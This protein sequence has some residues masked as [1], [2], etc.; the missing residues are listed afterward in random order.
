MPIETEISVAPQAFGAAVAWAAKWV[1]AKPNVPVQGGLMLRVVENRLTVSA[2]SERASVRATVECAPYSDEPGGAIVSGRLLAALC[3]TLTSRT[4]VTLVSIDDGSAVR[5]TQG[6]WVVTLPAMAEGDY[7]SVLGEM[8]EIGTVAGAELARAVE[9]I[10]M[11][12]PDEGAKVEALFHSM[13]VDLGSH[14]TIEVVSTDRYRVGRVVFPWTPAAGHPSTVITPLG[15]MMVDAAAAFDGPD[16]VRIGTDGNALSLSSPTRSLT[17]TTI[18]TEGKWPVTFLRSAG[19]EERPCVAVIE[20]AELIRPLKRASIMRGKDG[21][22]AV[23]F[24][25]GALALVASAETEGLN[26]RSDDEMAV[27]YTGPEMIVGFNPDYFADALASAPGAKVKLHF[28][29]D[30]KHVILTSDDDPDWRH[31]L[32]PVVLPR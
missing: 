10:A 20:P 27:D 2:Y 16:D 7:P 13:H 23:R 29:I 1:A 30:R 12:V 3:G 22:V 5:M 17:M 9:R 4:A 18:D 25:E 8:P 11:A 31:V 6:K 21:P 19:D 15:T 14:G 28:G 24:T 26:R 32:M